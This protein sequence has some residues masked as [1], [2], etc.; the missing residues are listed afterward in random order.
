M[1]HSL[2]RFVGL[3]I[4]CSPVLQIVI[5]SSTST[6][7]LRVP[8]EGLAIAALSYLTAKRKIG[9]LQIL[10]EC[11]LASLC[12]KRNVIQSRLGFLKR[13]LRRTYKTIAAGERPTRN[14]LAASQF[15][16]ESASK[17]VE[18]AEKV[19]AQ[20]AMLPDALTSSVNGLDLSNSKKQCHADYECTSTTDKDRLI[21]GR[22]YDPANKWL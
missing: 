16:Y 4:H 21:A 22:V 1:I 9:R 14:N 8:M 6:Y 10:G 13:K 15:K 19:R 20:Q 5:T 12:P 17:L 11:Q 18:Y 2:N 3:P 7:F